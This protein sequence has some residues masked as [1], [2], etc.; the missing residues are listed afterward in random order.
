MPATRITMSQRG[1][2]FDSSTAASIMRADGGH[3]RKAMLFGALLLAIFYTLQYLSYSALPGN[4]PAFPLGWWGWF[5]QSKTL[6]SAKAF[7]HGDLAAVH[8]WYPL[9]Y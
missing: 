9:G 1:A 2:A 8:H 3:A 5:D 6:E 7:A 4:Q